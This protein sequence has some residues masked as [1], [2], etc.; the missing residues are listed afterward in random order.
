MKR[1]GIIGVGLLGSA[2]ASRLLEGGFQVSGYDTRP[3]QVKALQAKGLRAASNLAEAAA[4]TDAVFTILPSLES[5][6][7]TV[8]SAGGLIEMA[9]PNCTLVQMSTISPELTRR[10]G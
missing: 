8:I 7:A 6:E 10:L 9:P 5:V 1:I 2:V 3:D 4:D